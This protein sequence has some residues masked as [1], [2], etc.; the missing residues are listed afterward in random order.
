MKKYY[1]LIYA[2][3]CC[4]LLNPSHTLQASNLNPDPEHV[5]DV[6]IVGGGIAGL[7]TAYMLRDKD[8]LLFEKEDRFGGKI[9]SDNI[10]GISYNIGTQYLIEE[11]NSF[12]Q[13]LDEIGVQRNLYSIMDAPMAAYINGQYY[14][15]LTAMPLGPG[16]LFDLIRIISTAYQKQKIFQMDPA[17]P[18]WKEL[19]RKTLIE[20]IKTDNEKIM[21]IFRAYLQGACVTKPEHVSAGV[22]ASLMGD[23]YNTA[24]FAFV[25][26]GTQKITDTMVAK[27]KGKVFNNTLVKNLK[28]KDGIVQVVIERDGNTYT[29]K[30][31]KAVIATDAP[32]CLGLLPDCPAWK[33][34]A[35]EK[36]EYGS[37]ITV[38]VFF[39]EIPWQR[40]MGMLVDDVIFTGVID[41]TY[42][43]DQ[44][45]EEEAYPKILNFFISIP[46][47]EKDLKDAMLAKSDQEIASLAI[48]DF[49]KIFP[50]IEMS[51]YI[52]GTRVTKF[53]HGEV[54]LTPEFFE[55]LPDL[56]KPVGNIHFCGDYTDRISFLRGAVLSGFR[57][58]R[59]LGSEYV[60]SQ[61]DE[62]RFPQ[63]KKWGS[64]GFVTIIVCVLIT[65]FGF[66]LRL[67]RKT[68]PRYA[69]IL[70]IVSIV[71]LVLTI[72]YPFYLPP[73]QVLYQALGAFIVVVASLGYFIALIWNRF[74]KHRH[75]NA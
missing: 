4:F 64:S 41:T 66:Y 38:N 15:D 31:R 6:I 39:K 35:L 54:S 37:I 67:A 74:K 29:L 59:E 40:F 14:H 17:D 10:K 52:V 71:V 70:I 43:N 20:I 11:D 72:V 63:T 9:W 19:A 49:G 21:A 13:M 34:T 18:R 57:A 60:V 75:V 8:L 3:L 58:A 51:D 56:Q 1:I 68:H 62:I 25:E 28:E 26:G 53:M 42:F 23:I 69:L 46:P 44:S 50:G 45:G 30:S 27:L 16:D 36:I 73:Y 65:L 33:K 32:A 7:T 22:G 61:S 5:Y 47:N 2:C 12:V 24:P 55:I 48:S